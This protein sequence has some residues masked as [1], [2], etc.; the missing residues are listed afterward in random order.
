MR[1]RSCGFA[2]KRLRRMTLSR[3]IHREPS[4]L[5]MCALGWLY[6][7]EER[8]IVWSA[9]EFGTSQEAFRDMCT[10]IESNPDLDAEVQK[11]HYANGDEAIEL[12]GDRRLKFKARTKSGGRGLT[13]NRI[14]LDEAMYLRPGHM[15]SLVPTLR[16][17]RDPQLLLAGSAGMVDS[18]VWRSYRDRGRA[19]G[20]PRLGWL[21]YADP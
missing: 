3:R 17:V 12:T 10:L 19:G 9:H 15:G 5:K 2:P 11:I 1:Q 13:G 16:A 14:V 7:T 6:V 4:L 21:E 8:L 18:A 20:D